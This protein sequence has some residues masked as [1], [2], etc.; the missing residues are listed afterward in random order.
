VEFVTFN[1][2]GMTYRFAPIKNT[3]NMDLL[4]MARRNEQRKL[5]AL[6]LKLAKDS[7]DFSEPSPDCL[8]RRACILSVRPAVR[9]TSS[10]SCRW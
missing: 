2:S 4:V 9:R 10:L 3:S 8:V 1:S 7:S 6:L 5:E